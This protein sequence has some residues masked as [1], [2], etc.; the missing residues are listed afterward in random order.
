M[1]AVD[2]LLAHW[3]AQGLPLAKG[4]PEEEIKTFESRYALTL[5]D[6]LR[7]YFMRVNGMVQQGGVDTDQEGFAFWPLERVRPLAVVC[8]EEKVA[9]PTV[10]EPDRYLVIADYLQWSWGFAIRI[11]PAENIVILV[12]VM[13]NGV[14]ANSFTEFVSLYVDDAEALYPKLNP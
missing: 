11:G 14:I 4:V 7:T 5:P 12:G 13:D 1:I 9:I 8:E 10:E 3:A 2:R 6:D